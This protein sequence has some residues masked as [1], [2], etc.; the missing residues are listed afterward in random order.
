[1]EEE[2]SFQL[3][4]GQ[5]DLEVLEAEVLLSKMEEKEQQ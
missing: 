3:Q 5:E 2:A 1:V 4:G